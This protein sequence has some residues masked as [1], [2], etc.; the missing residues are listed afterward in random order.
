[1]LKIAM[2]VDWDGKKYEFEKPMVVHRL[3]EEL[4]L[5]KEAHLVVANNRLVTEDHKLEADDDVRVI[6]VIS[7]G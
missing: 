5:S 1:M 6:R 7:G 4:S 3:L 2:K